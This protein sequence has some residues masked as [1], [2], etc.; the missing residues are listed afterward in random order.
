MLCTFPMYFLP[1]CLQKMKENQ[2]IVE[3]ISK[4][5]LS[6]EI[7]SCKGGARRTALKVKFQDFIENDVDF[8]YFN[9]Y[10]AKVRDSQQ[11]NEAENFGT[12]KLAVSSAVVNS[13][14]INC[15]II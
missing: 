1:Y 11:D 13:K 2:F 14:I 8:D 10:L 12:E 4:I 15:I 6:V 9:E 5:S 3:D 7:D